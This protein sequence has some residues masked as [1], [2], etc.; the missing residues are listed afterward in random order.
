MDNKT[1][2]EDRSKDILIDDL[3]GVCMPKSEIKDDHDNK[4]D[5]KDGEKFKTMNVQK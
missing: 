5:F 3:M 1:D 2:K 4:R